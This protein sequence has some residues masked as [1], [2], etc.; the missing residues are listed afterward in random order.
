[1]ETPTSALVPQVQALPSV[2]KEAVAFDVK[3][4]ELSLDDTPA[5]FEMKLK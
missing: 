1:L 3:S 2:K 5:V 4:L